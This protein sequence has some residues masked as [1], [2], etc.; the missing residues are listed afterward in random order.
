MTGFLIGALIVALLVL[1]P[2]TRAGQRGGL[3]PVPSYLLPALL[4]MISL[5]GYALLGDPRGLA[6]ASVTPETPDIAAMV[7][8]LEDHLVEQPEDLEGWAM[9]G[10]SYMVLGRYADARDAYERLLALPN[11]DSL[12]VRV[13]HAEAWVM[14]EPAALAGPAGE[15]FERALT[16][17]PSH[18][19]ALWYGGLAARQRGD[20]GVAR[21]RWQRLLLQDPPEPLATLLRE[22]LGMS[23]SS[24][25]AIEVLVTDG[26]GELAAREGDV[27]FVFARSPDGGMPLA[28]QRLPGDL[29]IRVLLGRGDDLMDQGRPLQPPLEIVAR[30]SASGDARPRT[31]DREGRV[32]LEEGGSVE[33]VI[34]TLIE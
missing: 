25:E 5:L 21:D 16:Q 34:D 3:G 17:A 19:K 7:A 32:I 33:V 6:P 23:T 4:L 29:P 14:A 27:L 12:D 8:S 28:A 13:D 31:G 1:G 22:Q 2:V 24:D 20:E 30:L 9:L 15:R 18:P 26:G 11:G 10:R